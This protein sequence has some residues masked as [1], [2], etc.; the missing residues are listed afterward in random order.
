LRKTALLVVICGFIFLASLSQ[1]QQADAMLGFGTIMSSGSTACGA[2]SCVIPERGGLYPTISADVIFHKRVGFNFE[3]SWRARQG[4]YA[5]LGIP[6]RPILFDFNGVYQPH[7][8]KKVGVDLMGGIGWQSTRF[9]GYQPTSNCVYFGACYTSS[10]HFLVDVGGG[11]R[12]Y[13]RGHVFVRPEAHFYHIV[14]NTADFS[15]NNVVR[16]GAAIGYTI[17]PD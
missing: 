1:A 17:G 12:Y 10:N 5:G 16:V 8:S 9:Y 7:L 4:N 13:V 14:N 15:S 3:A 6:F 2:N 11:I